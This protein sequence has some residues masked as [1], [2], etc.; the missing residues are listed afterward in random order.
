MMREVF[1]TLETQMPELL[2]EMR[3]DLANTP[4][5]RELV[6]LD[7]KWVFNGTGQLEYYTD[8]HVDLVGKFQILENHNL[9]RDI[10]FNSVRRYLMSELLAAYLCGQSRNDVPQ[11]PRIKGFTKGHT[12]R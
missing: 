1:T 3:A 4:L 6:L 10:T 5:K 12:T 9:V 11:S 2:A 8:R 7:S